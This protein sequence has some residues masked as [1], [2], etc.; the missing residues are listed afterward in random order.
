M[1]FGQMKDYIIVRVS[2]N[3][4]VNDTAGLSG[5]YHSSVSVGTAKSEP[6]AQIVFYKKKKT[7][8]LRLANSEANYGSFT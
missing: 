1:N 4:R 3:I 2:F 5:L 7:Q 8:S 6:R